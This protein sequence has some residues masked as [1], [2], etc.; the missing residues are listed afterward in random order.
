MTYRGQVVNGVVV[1]YGPD[2]PPE[3]AVVSVRVLKRKPRNEAEPTPAFYDRCKSV[4]A[5][6]KGFP[7]DASGQP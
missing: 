5:K 3:G 7:S 6:A 1:L 4:I 2:Y